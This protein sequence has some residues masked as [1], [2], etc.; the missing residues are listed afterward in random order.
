MYDDTKA[1]IGWHRDKIKGLKI[2]DKGES[3]VVSGSFSKSEGTKGA[4]AVM[5]FRKGPKGSADLKIELNHGT[6][7][8]FD[9]IA[10][11]KMKIYHQV[12]K[13]LNPRINLT[14]RSQ[15][16]EE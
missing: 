7:V 9:A 6:V 5:E 12:P 16:A 13:T 3:W 15:V 1:N 4:L 10:H 2:N 8:M 11:E 14:M